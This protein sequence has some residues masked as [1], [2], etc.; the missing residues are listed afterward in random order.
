[1]VN[2]L[3]AFQVKPDA[4]GHLPPKETV[5]SRIIAL[6]LFGASAAMLFGYDLG[7]CYTPALL[8]SSTGRR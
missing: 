8:D 6:A 2:L 7:E 1:M 4:N 5:N 3:S